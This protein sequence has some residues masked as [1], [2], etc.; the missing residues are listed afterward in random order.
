MTARFV[1][2]Q[3]FFACFCLCLVMA[4]TSLIFEVVTLSALTHFCAV[5]GLTPNFCARAVI[6]VC[7]FARHAVINSSRLVPRRASFAPVRVPF[8][9][10]VVVVVLLLH[11]PHAP[12]RAFAS[13]A[14]SAHNPPRQ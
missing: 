14:V 11:A 1:L 5:R 2:G 4:L 7:P 10:V 12:R 13:W 9:P 6:E 8:A 3:I